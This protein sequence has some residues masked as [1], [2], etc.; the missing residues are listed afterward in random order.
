[1]ITFWVSMQSIFK[2]ASNCLTLFVR[3]SLMHGLQGLGA[4]K[5]SFLRANKT[6]ANFEYALLK[7]SPDVLEVAWHQL[8]ISQVTSVNNG[9]ANVR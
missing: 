5:F 1:M 2:Q 9:T 8:P 7:F 3:P 6:L 4:Q